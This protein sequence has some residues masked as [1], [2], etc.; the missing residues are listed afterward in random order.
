MALTR[1]AALFPEVVT[2]DI[3]T[4]EDQPGWLYAQTCKTWWKRS[5][6]VD[7]VTILLVYRSPLVT[8][9]SRLYR[10]I[11]EQILAA[12]RVEVIGTGSHF[13]PEFMGE[14]GEFMIARTTQAEAF[15][16]GPLDM[17]EA[18]AVVARAASAVL[19]QVM[20]TV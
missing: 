16:P 14:R 17:A 11:A 10:P 6:D 1:I 7:P 5:L 2:A 12:N 13:N 19:P 3:K 15:P 18:R 9:T 8:E 4:I 20:A